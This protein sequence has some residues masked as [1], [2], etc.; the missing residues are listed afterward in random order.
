M[1]NEKFTSNDRLNN[2]IILSLVAKWF[3]LDNRIKL[4]DRIGPAMK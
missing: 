4:P 1:H 2:L 3:F